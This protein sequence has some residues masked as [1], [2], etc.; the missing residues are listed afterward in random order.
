MAVCKDW[1]SAKTIP[2]MMEIA[3]Q[4]GREFLPPLGA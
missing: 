4:F 3:K 2:R 1:P